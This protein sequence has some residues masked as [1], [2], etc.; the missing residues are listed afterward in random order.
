MQRLIPFLISSLITGFVIV[1]V[2]PFAKAQ[3][4]KIPGAATVTGN[5]VGQLVVVGAIVMLG[6]GVFGQ[7]A[8]RVIAK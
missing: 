8:K 7:I 6:L 5:K 4:D 1:F 3:V 2:L